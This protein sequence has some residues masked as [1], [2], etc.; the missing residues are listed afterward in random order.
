MRNKNI[1]AKDKL[2]LETL[3][4]KYGNKN[5]AR[6]INRLNESNNSNDPM[7][8][9]GTYA[10]YNNGSLEGEW[11]NLSDFSDKD[12]FIEYCLE[13]HSDEEK[14]E[15]MFQDYENVPKNL[16]S[17]SDIDES[18][19]EILPLYDEY[20]EVFIS[21][22]MNDCGLS[23]YDELQSAINDMVVYYA[24]S[25][26]EAVERYCDETMMTTDLDWC[27]RYFD[28]DS[29]GYDIRRDEFIESELEDIEDEDE[30]KEKEEE[31]DNMSDSE[32]AKY[33]IDLVGDIREAVGE[34]NMDKYIDY[35]YVARDLGYDC[36]IIESEINNQPVVAFIYR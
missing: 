7:V 4:A 13:L 26:E 12:D 21:T 16:I 31:F 10:K 5:V 20:G 24:D 11:V 22:V 28:Y 19:W 27:E 23:D 18:L 9:V 34:N 6:V 32:L 2:L 3:I 36:D 33:Y 29:F 30:R 8:Y 35:G 17:E 1:N 14:P 15:L 25:I